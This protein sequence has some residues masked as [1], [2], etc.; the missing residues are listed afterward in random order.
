L[1]TNQKQPLAFDVWTTESGAVLLLKRFM[2]T[3]I[4]L[5]LSLFS[6]LSFGQ[7]AI[8]KERCY[9]KIKVGAENTTYYFDHVNDLEE[10]GE[11][12]IS[13]V[14]VP[15]KKQQQATDLIPEIAI[16]I[17]NGE[18]TVVETITPN[19]VLFKET[20]IKLKAQLDIPFPK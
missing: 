15:K 1:K 6:W 8:Q 12:V 2:R 9:I 17:T 7:E 14:A 18:K 16:S 19:I 13:E 4:I 10:H 20:L 11:N 5:F 3:A